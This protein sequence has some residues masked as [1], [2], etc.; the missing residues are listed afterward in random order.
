MFFGHGLLPICHC[1]CLNC[2]LVDGRSAVI[3]S[4][5]DRII[6]VDSVLGSQYCKLKLE[7]QQQLWQVIV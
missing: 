5:I 6:V 3:V 7:A 4:Y 1:Q 2:I